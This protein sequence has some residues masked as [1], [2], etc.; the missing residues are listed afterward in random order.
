MNV[1][2]CYDQV[3]GEGSRLIEKGI[4]MTDAN[5]SGA[6]QAQDAPKTK[7]VVFIG[8]DGVQLRDPFDESRGYGSNSSN[9]TDL[10]RNGLVDGIMKLDV[11]EAR[12]GGT[13]EIPTMACS[14][15]LL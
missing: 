9:L 13:R 1:S 12:T 5:S 11:V 2:Y 7:H 15:L 14:F 4:D 8:V 10:N 3:D 6:N